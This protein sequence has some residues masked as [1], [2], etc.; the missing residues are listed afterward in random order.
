M[1]PYNWPT[2]PVYVPCISAFGPTNA[3]GDLGMPCCCSC[4]EDMVGRKFKAPTFFMAFSHGLW[5]WARV[6]GP[7]ACGLVACGL[8]SR[9]HIQGTD[10]LYARAA[11]SLHCTAQCTVMV[12]LLHSFCVVAV[13][14]WHSHGT[15][16]THQSLRTSHCR[17]SHCIVSCCRHSSVHHAGK[18]WRALWHGQDLVTR[19]IFPCTRPETTQVK[20]LSLL[21]PGLMRPDAQAATFESKQNSFIFAM[22]GKFTLRRGQRHRRNFVFVQWAAL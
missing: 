15:V 10:I 17:A 19:L 4:V 22:E 9:A 1:V 14:S 3:V 12:H 7:L 2:R 5:L 6:C 11:I 13:Q 18:N 8:W 20:Q 16:T 21:G